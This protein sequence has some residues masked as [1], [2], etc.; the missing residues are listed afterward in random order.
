MEVAFRNDVTE[1][2][3][4]FCPDYI[5]PGIE[6]EQEAAESP[7]KNYQIDAFLYLLHQFMGNNFEFLLVSMTAIYYKLGYLKGS[8]FTGINMSR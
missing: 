1:M 2:V 5:T 4:Q 6:I 8:K 7:P 3:S